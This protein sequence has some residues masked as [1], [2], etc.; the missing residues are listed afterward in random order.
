MVLYNILSILLPINRYMGN[1]TTKCYSGSMSDNRD[2][3]ETLHQKFSSLP[4]VI[5]SVS[6]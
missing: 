6:R 2:L 4:K 3:T 5:A 1:N